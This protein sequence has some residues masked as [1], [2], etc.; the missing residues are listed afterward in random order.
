ML[1][2]EKMKFQVIP[3][4]PHDAVD[5][6]HVL[7]NSITKACGPDYQN[8]EKIIHN[9]LENKTPENVKKWISSSDNYSFVA[10]DNDG[11]IVGF[12]LMN[13]S[14]EILLNYIEPKYMHRG[15]GK[16]FL[17]KFEETAKRN[18]IHEITVY[19]TITAKDFY[20]RN[21]FLFCG[22]PIMIGSIVGEFPMKKCLR[23][24]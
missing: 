13:R 6:C 20:L 14:G 4:R 23:N 21:G 19:S 9:W 16:L 11:A 3:P 7:I 8:D 18:S 1:K 15:I 2:T 17:E 5:I 24:L 10:I 12:S 22:E